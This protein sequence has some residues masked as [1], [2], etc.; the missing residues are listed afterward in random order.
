MSPKS[1]W[2]E[3]CHNTGYV[4]CYCGGDLCICENNGEEECPSCGGDFVC[5]AFDVDEGFD[6][7]EWNNT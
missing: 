1:G 2:C 3:T 7:G 6:A 4:N 5:D